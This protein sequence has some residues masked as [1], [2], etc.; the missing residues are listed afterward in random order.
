MAMTENCFDRVYRQ[1]Q[2][3]VAGWS[4]GTSPGGADPMVRFLPDLFRLLRRVT[5]DLEMPGADRRLAAAAVLYIADPNDFLPDADETAADRRLD[6]LWVAFATF[7]LLVQSGAV[8]RLE[9]HWRSEIPFRELMECRSHMAALDE[10][11]PPRVL[12]MVNQYLGD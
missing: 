10:A 6:D 12:Q 11:I 8:A 2:V 3:L 1:L 5:Y 9:S 4:A 7:F